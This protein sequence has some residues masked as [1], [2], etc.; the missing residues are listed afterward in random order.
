[1]TIITDHHS[2]EP[3]VWLF[4]ALLWVMRL[5]GEQ[6]YAWGDAEIACDTSAARAWLA[7]A[8]LTPL[9]ET[10]LTT[11]AAERTRV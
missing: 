1:M 3:P 4:R 5:I 6:L 2:S 11:P 9:P 7:L 8:L 10:A